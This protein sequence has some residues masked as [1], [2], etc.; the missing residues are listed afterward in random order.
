MCQLLRNL[1]LFSGS[2]REPKIYYADTRNVVEN[3]TLVDRFC[4]DS[5]QQMGT[6]VG[7]KSAPTTNESYL[8]IAYATPV[9][10][11]Y[12]WRVDKMM[13]WNTTD[14]SFFYCDPY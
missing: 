6:L 7:S 14:Y 5:D 2:T 4:D 12:H 8:E 13:K 3:G 9:D 11:P 10:E 1:C